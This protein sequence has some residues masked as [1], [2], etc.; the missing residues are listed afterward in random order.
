MKIKSLKIS[1]K[2]HEYLLAQGSKS[3][4]FEDVIWRLI[5]NVKKRRT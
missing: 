1:E 5:K 3:E 4:T 2:L